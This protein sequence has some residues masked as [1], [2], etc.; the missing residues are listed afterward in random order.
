[1]WGIALVALAVANAGTQVFASR[2]PSHHSDEPHAG[3]KSDARN[4]LKHLG[5]SATPFCSSLLGITATTT[6]TYVETPAKH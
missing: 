2:S 5:H 4:A 6:S 3:A 1:M